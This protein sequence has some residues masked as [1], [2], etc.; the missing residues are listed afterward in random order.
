VVWREQV[1]GCACACE[2]SACRGRET[3]VSFMGCRRSRFA[4]TLGCKGDGEVPVER[5]GMGVLWL[6]STAGSAAANAYNGSTQGG[7]ERRS[8]AYLLDWGRKG[9]RRDESE[10]GNVEAMQDAQQC[11]CRRSGAGLATSGSGGPP[12]PRWA[13][14]A[15]VFSSGGTPVAPPLFFLLLLLFSLSSTLLLAAD[16]KRTRG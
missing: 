16:R 11:R 9:R 12:P 5:N 14:G 6:V 2:F 13:S 7:Q 8:V 10:Q 3:A 15:A 1:Q 4:A